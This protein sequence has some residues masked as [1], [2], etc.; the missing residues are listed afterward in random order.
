[1]RFLSSS[2]GLWLILIGSLPMVLFHITSLLS[3]DH[4]QFVILLPI[5][6]WFLFRRSKEVTALQPGT[7]SLPAACLL[8]VLLVPLA[9]ASW[10]FSPWL[11]VAT[12]FLGVP[13]VLLA[14]GGGK[15]CRTLLPLWLLSAF[16]VA[17]P[18]NLDRSLIA[19]LRTYATGMS[20]KV[21]DLFHLQHNVAGNLIEIPGHKLFIAD[22]CSGIHSLFVLLA[23]AT[24]V[25][26]WNQRSFLRGCIVLA[27]TF[28]LVMTE[29]VAR[30]TLIA[31][32]FRFGIDLS[33]GWPHTLLGLFLFLVSIGLVCSLD[34]LQSFFTLRT[35]GN[36]SESR[37]ASFKAVKHSPVT[38][39]VVVVGLGLIL[40]MPV[41]LARMPRGQ[42][43]GLLVA[44]QPAMRI[45]RMSDDVLPE[46]LGPYQRT[47][48]E[49][50]ERVEEDPFG[51]QSQV[52]TYRHGDIDLQISLDYP[53][54]SVHDTCTCYRNTGW[55]V[56][57]E[58]VLGPVDTG[59]DLF[60]SQP[61]TSV[62][63]LPVLIA[64][65][66]SP[67]YGSGILLASALSPTGSVVV[68]I[69]SRRLLNQN[70]LVKRFIGFEAEAASAGQYVQLQ[71]I[72]LSPQS[73]SNDQRAELASLYREVREVLFAQCVKS[74]SK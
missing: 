71:M 42:A 5:A 46:S 4:F 33:I 69:D 44:L 1:V 25:V 19:R 28:L 18:L 67:G 8:L 27:G 54:S 34:Q 21:L 10:W 45:D 51:P 72:A 52:W 61:D 68:A 35:N 70:H 24:V 13:L 60:E 23:F 38:W 41:T 73:L 15:F 17:L 9:V 26:I 66:G 40:L 65:I 47:G 43:S 53:Y 59:A 39:P 48:F 56:L 55:T 11:H 20:S 49:M 3:K 22:A 31:A 2:V 6:A 58:R 50:I 30:L 14:Y 62:E 63:Q 37:E 16:V 36:F 7:G 57:K 32:A 29:N 74:S 64:D 12:L